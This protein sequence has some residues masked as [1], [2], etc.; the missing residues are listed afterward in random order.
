MTS[1][2]RNASLGGEHARNEE[3]PAKVI[4]NM[5]TAIGT[6]CYADMGQTV[7]MEDVRQLQE[8]ITM[9]LAA[10]ATSANMAA[11]NP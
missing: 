3:G 11:A 8:H 6:G 9:F 1:L 7:I 2:N 5:A 4:G 10:K